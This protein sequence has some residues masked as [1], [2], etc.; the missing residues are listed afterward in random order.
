MT[1]RNGQGT[2]TWGDGEWAG[3]KYVGE[4]KEWLEKKWPWN[5]YV[6]RW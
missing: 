6:R 4:F 3:D 1:M 2:F 5:L